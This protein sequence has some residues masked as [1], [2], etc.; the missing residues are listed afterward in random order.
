MTSAHA[1]AEHEA[2]AG[3]LGAYA[4]DA[5]EPAETEM[6]EAHLRTCAQCATEVARHHEVASLLADSEADAPAHVW[7]RIAER[8]DGPEHPLWESLAARLERPPG[9]RDILADQDPPPAETRRSAE[10]VPIAGR[11]DRRSLATRVIALVAAAAAVLAILLGIQVSRLDHRV[12]QLR[13]ATTPGL[14][15]VV[16]TALEE[17]S[18]DRVA[19]AA[20]QPQ[21]NTSAAV[22]VAV[23]SY[24]TAYV[25][26]HHLP[27]LPASRTYQL[28]GQIDGRMISLG[29]L[30][31]D[32]TVSAV[33]VDAQAPVTLFAISIERSTGAL[34]PTGAPV[35]QGAVRS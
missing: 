3:L 14:S 23:T 12:S 20:A 13:A 10:I 6:V 7:D 16:Q 30:G 28:W 31:P 8:L 19:L 22:T 15:G 29:L 27:I 34:Q 17:P 26:P 2:I 5:L 24:G 21:G 25:I 4:L 11:R 33:S 18:T 35:V 1:D 32:P 9:T